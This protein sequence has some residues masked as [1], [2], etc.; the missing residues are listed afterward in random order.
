MNIVFLGFGWVISNDYWFIQAFI[1]SMS[2]NK[3]KKV[4]SL[5]KTS[6]D[7]HERIIAR[8]Y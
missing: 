7:N 8:K 3:S 5:D 4:T 1:I 6:L 2:D